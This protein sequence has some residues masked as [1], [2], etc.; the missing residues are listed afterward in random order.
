MSLPGKWSRAVMALHRPWLLPYRCTLCGLYLAAQDSSIFVPGSRTD[1]GMK[2]RRQ[3]VCATCL[4][5]MFSKEEL[6]DGG[7]VRHGD[8]LPPHKY[9]RNTPT[10]VTTPTK[11]LLNVGRRT[12]TTQK[13][14]GAPTRCQACASAVG[15]PC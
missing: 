14:L 2:K 3:M 5:R 15:E 11:H 12:Q 13:G 6:Q 4:L 9:I 1:K 10:C 8:H 7:R